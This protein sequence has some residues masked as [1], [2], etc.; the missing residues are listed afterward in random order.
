MDSEHDDEDFQQTGTSNMLSTMDRQRRE[1]DLYRREKEL[2]ERELAMVR[3]ELEM[4]RR[5]LQIERNMENEQQR[6]SARDIAATVEHDQA[7]AT[8][9]MM[10]NNNVGK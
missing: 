6:Q 3:L 8:S 10:A 5:E 7:G 4:M 9:V 1:I 2:T